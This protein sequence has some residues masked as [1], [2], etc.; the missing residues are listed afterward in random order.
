MFHCCISDGDTINLLLL[1]GFTVMSNWWLKELK[2]LH[3]SPGV[4]GLMEMCCWMGLHVEYSSYNGVT[5]IQDFEVGK[6]CQV[7][8]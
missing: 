5:Q 7:V 8:I 2:D 1:S 4:G 6:F 3:I